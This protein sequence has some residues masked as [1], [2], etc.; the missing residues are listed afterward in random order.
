[1]KE[2]LIEWLDACIEKYKNTEELEN[3]KSNDCC[4]SALGFS[5]DFDPCS[6]EHDKTMIGLQVSDIRDL[7]D[8][9]ELKD[10]YI[11]RHNDRY[12]ELWFVYKEV[13]IYGLVEK[14]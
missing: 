10:Y 13:A 11:R 12:N 5:S 3:F 14:G 4:I 6:E 7:I 8:G 2:K 9:L 1:M